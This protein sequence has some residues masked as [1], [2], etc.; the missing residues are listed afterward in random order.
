MARPKNFSHKIQVYLDDAALTILRAE[1]ARLTTR[2]GKL[3][4]CLIKERARTF[5][6]RPLQVIDK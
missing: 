4:S 2:P 5:Y 6:T 1:V 3:L